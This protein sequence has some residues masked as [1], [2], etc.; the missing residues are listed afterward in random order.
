MS[1]GDYEGLIALRAG[2]DLPREDEGRLDGHLAGCSACR[3]FAQELQEYQIV[4]MR[5]RSEAPD[6]DLMENVRRNVLARIKE[7]RGRSVGRWRLQFPIFRLPLRFA[8]GVAI[9]SLLV[10]SF[11]LAS[12][13]RPQ[14]REVQLP[15]RQSAAS[16]SLGAADPR[17]ETQTHVIAQAGAVPKRKVRLTASS[18]RDSRAGQPEPGEKMEEPDTSALKPLRI[19]LQT[20]DPKIRII[21][22][23]P[24]RSE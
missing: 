3:E 21:W 4:L 20:A 23:V 10:V 14:G 24:Q 13:R 11:W 19:E 6:A 15:S 16:L 9:A 17:R 5:W 1:C 22:F 8:A 7:G 2:G 12:H 18:P